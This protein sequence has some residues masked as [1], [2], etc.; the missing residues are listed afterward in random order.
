MVGGSSTPPGSIDHVWANERVFLPG[1][2]LAAACQLGGDRLGPQLGELAALAVV[3][4]PGVRP[5]GRWTA[6]AGRADQAPFRDGTFDLVAVDDTAG[7]GQPLGPVLQ[8]GRRLCRSTGSLLIGSHAGVLERLR[9]WGSPRRERAVVLTALPSLRRPAF[10]LR[11]DDPEPVRYFVRRVAFA[12]RQPGGPSGRAG[13]HQ[14]A[15]RLALAAP[16]RL[17]IRGQAARVELLPGADAP[18]SLLDRLIGLVLDAWSGLELPGPPPARLSPLVVGHRRPTTG[19]VTVLLF[20]P[21]DRSPSVVAKLPRYGPTGVPLRREA[22]ALDAVWAALPDGVRRAIPRPLGLHLVDGTQVLLQTGVPGSHLF[23][24]TA[25]GWLRPAALARQLGL[26]LAWCSALQSASTR[27]VVTDDSL[28]AEKLEPPAKEVVALLD[29]DA[30]VGSLLDRTIEQARALRGTR[31]PL[32]ASHGDY[33][34]GNLFVQDGRVCGVVDWERAALDDL[35]LWDP[36]KAVGSAA[37]HLD[38]YRSVPRR[39][40]AALPGWGD[41]GAWRGVAEP[42]FAAGF[43][44]AFVQPCWLADLCRD[45]LVTSLRRTGVPLGWLPTAMVMYLVRQV[46]Q[47]TDS[48]RSVAGWGSVLRALAVSPATW[49][50]ELGDRRTY[51]TKERR[52]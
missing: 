6:V 32:V 46:L 38:R 15:G 26:A 43:R 47:A 35:P 31:L 19:M 40:P 18:P 28:L 23:G 27:W 41:L 48:P 37:Y 42:Q 2:R 33:W 22:A 3:V 4:G 51:I 9:P 50:D 49:A 8:E 36:V 17:A 24:T 21:D 12:H 20:R 7:I 30:K 45:A 16:P 14:A 44:A 52:G 10:L 5:G 34:A 29:G 1:G 25:S 13:I 39:G 11:P